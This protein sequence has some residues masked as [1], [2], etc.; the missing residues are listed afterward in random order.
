M[1]IQRNCRVFGLQ[2]NG[3]LIALTIYVSREEAERL[4]SLLE[5]HS[6]FARLTI[7]CD[8]ESDVM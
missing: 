5:P 8:D 7:E 2:D 1:T 3:E 6:A 4:L